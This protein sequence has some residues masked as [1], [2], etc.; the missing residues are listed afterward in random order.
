MTM[1]VGH[2]EMTVEVKLPLPQR[3]QM[4]ARLAGQ[5]VS[6]DEINVVYT[7]FFALWWEADAAE[8]FEKAVANFVEGD[9]RWTVEWLGHTVFELE[10]AVEGWQRMSELQALDA[11]GARRLSRFV[12]DTSAHV[13]ELMELIASLRE[14]AVSFCEGYSVPLPERLRVMLLWKRMS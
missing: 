8:S 3:T 1:V 14:Q 4:W 13:Q 2:Q 7:A 5:A 6:F 12:K 11:L 10:K 9:M